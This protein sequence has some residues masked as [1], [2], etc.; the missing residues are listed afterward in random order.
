MKLYFELKLVDERGEVQAAVRH[1]FGREAAYR[2]DRIGGEMRMGVGAAS[3][4]DAVKVLKVREFRKRLLIDTAK[5]AGAQLAEFLEDREG[6]HGLD[7][8]EGVERSL[9]RRP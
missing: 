2:G 3:F 8:Q 1:K 9:K 5:Q 7:R 4:E 6:W